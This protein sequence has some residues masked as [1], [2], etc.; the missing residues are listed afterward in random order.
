MTDKSEYLKALEGMGPQAFQ[1]N[2]DYGDWIAEN[3]DTIRRALR[4]APVAE[5][6]AAYLENEHDPMAERLK[7]A[8]KK[9]M[10]AEMINEVSGEK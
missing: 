8:Y 3:H 4:I 1:M 5:L 7:A 9:A 2:M 6:M 10:A